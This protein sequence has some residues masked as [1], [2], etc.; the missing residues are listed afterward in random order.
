MQ[1]MP[2][3]SPLRLPPSSPILTGGRVP[4]S[5]ILAGTPERHAALLFTPPSCPRSSWQDTELDD[6]VRA[7][8]KIGSVPLLSFA[9][10]RHDCYCGIDHLF[11]AA[12][13]RQQPKALELLLSC[14]TMNHLLDMPC[15][16]QTPLH[17][18]V[19]MSHTEDDVGC[20]M[21][22]MLLVSG[23]DVNATDLHSE[24]PLHKASRKACLAVVKILLQHGAVANLVSTS[25]STALHVL[26]DKAFYAA[27]DIAVLEELL[28]HGAAPALRNSDGL[29][30]CDQLGM[31]STSPIL[32]PIA[33]AMIKK[34]VSAE[35]QE[36]RR[37][38]RRSCLLLRA[39][40]GCGHICHHLPMEM[41]R[42]TV[43]FL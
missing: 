3:A 34:L 26:C 22:S 5:P 4:R 19:L 41:F 23:A 6:D 13:K 30:P 29:R 18:A 28:A 35:A 17:Q 14:G 11:H 31:A 37:Q 20:N 42:T 43:Q 7:A 36:E 1:D 38:A 15:R 12:I 32:D 40:P 10:S 33:S 39:R 25:G 24:T 9:F 27:G 2:L 21:T 16:G 8:F